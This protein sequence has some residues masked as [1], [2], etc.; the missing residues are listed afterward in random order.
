MHLS[1]GR[2]QTIHITD[3]GNG[4][5][6]LS[7]KGKTSPHAVKGAFVK[8]TI[9]NRSGGRRSAGVTSGFAKR[10]YRP[11][12]RKVRF[13]TSPLP[14]FT[15]FLRCMCSTTLPSSLRFSFPFYF[16]SCTST[17]GD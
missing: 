15:F 6:I 1:T 16:F 14:E 8:T 9:R 11:D 17:A 5:T 2:A 13:R 7:R 4:V 3:S 12:L 10:G